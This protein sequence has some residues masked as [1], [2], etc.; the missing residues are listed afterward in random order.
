MSILVCKAL[1]ILEYMTLNLPII[2]NWVLV[3]HHNAFKR[4][5]KGKRFERILVVGGGIYPR[6]A[7]VLKRMCPYAQVTIQDMS[8]ESLKVAEAYLKR[9]RNELNISFLHREY[10][11]TD[12]ST[13][14]STVYST[15]YST[16]YGTMYNSNTTYATTT[17]TVCPYDLVV[18]PLA[19]QCSTLIKSPSSCLNVRH[20]WIWENTDT[21]RST[22]VSYLLLKKL[23]LEEI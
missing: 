4:L 12:A 6:T 18:Y 15:E 22:I 11:P 10:A 3:V 5:L 8:R 13:I 23:V 1:N 14:Y 7:I 16:V 21:K 2:R 17:S 9:T 19:L 20:C